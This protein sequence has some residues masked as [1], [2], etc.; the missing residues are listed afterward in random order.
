[1]LMYQMTMLFFFFFSFCVSSLVR[2]RIYFSHMENMNREKKS[3]EPAVVYINQLYCYYRYYA[4]CFYLRSVLL[5]FRV[6]CLFVVVVFFLSSHWYC[7]SICSVIIFISLFLSVNC[8]DLTFL[9]AITYNNF[10]LIEC[11]NTKT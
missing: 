3:W 8:N 2:I 10:N 6:F 7:Y 9:S 5:P 1:M 11:A 4:I